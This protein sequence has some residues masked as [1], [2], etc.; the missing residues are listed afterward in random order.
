MLKVLRRQLKMIYQR[1]NAIVQSVF[2]MEMDLGFA[3][4]I[5]G[6]IELQRDMLETFSQ[7]NLQFIFFLLR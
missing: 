2:S 4:Q 6:Q 3:T 7:E 5:K 1:I